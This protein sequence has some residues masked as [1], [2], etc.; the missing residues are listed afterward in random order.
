MAGEITMNNTEF[1]K[2]RESAIKQAHDKLNT[3]INKLSKKYHQ[4]TEEYQLQQIIK[5]LFESRPFFPNKYSK[6]DLDDPDSE[7]SFKWEFVNTATELFLKYSDEVKPSIFLHYF[8]TEIIDDFIK[9]FNYRGNFKDKKTAILSQYIGENRI[10]LLTCIVYNIEFSN[11][12]FGT[13]VK[14][15]SVGLYPQDTRHLRKYLNL[16]DLPAQDSTRAE[17]VS[18]IEENDS[19]IEE[20]NTPGIK[21]LAILLYLLDEKNL[22]NFMANKDLAIKILKTNKLGAKGVV[23]NST[24]DS[25]FN[26]KRVA[27]YLHGQKNYKRK[28][29][30][31]K[32]LREIAN[33]LHRE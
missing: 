30:I 5:E 12:I 16:P 10:F 13:F 23:S 14:E 24:L 17:S 25:Y 31:A 9:K 6:N 18:N 11:A 22:F 7:D 26:S 21:D 20:Q 19:D 4:F 28:Q 33:R 1:E 8:F 32:L 29:Y 27:A 3:E 15:Y 2:A